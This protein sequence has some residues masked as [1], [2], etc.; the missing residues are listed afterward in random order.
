MKIAIEINPTESTLSV[1]NV[2]KQTGVHDSWSLLK[3]I[4][5]VQLCLMRW[6]YN[7]SMTQVVLC[8]SSRQFACDCCVG[9]EEYCGLL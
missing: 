5:S 6:A 8:K 2:K 1:Q 3:T 9:H 4:Y 7:K